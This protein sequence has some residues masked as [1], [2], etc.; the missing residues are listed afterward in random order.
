MSFF[1]RMFGG[2]SAEEE[3]READRLLAR[4]D[5]FEARQAYERALEKNKG[6]D[7]T[8]REHCEARLLECYD[9]MAE[10]RIADAERLR[11][12]GQLEIA[13]GELTTAIE[14]ARSASVRERARRAIE[15]LERRDAVEQATEQPE[16]SDDDRW[17]VIAGTWEQPQI[18]EY[19]E[20][21]DEFREAI[22]ALH[23]NRPK[24]ALPVIERLVEEH[25]EDATYL[26][27]E[28]GRARLVDGDEE[29]GADALR[30]FLDRMAESD[31]DDDDRSDAR[32]AAHLA[33]ASLADRKGDEE[34]AIDWLQKAMVAMP[35]DPRPY[36]QLGVYLREKGHADEAID[37]L[38]TAIELMDDDRPSWEAYQE[39]GL[40]KM[41]AGHDVEAIDL[42]EKVVRFFVSRSRLDFPRASALPLARLHEKQGQLERAADLYRNLAS[43]SDRANHLEYHREAAR[44]LTEL[45]LYS[46]ARRMLT[47][48]A[49]LAE[50][51]PAVLATVEADIVALD[52]RAD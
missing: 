9:A 25:G 44:V 38:E 10:E 20:Y 2:V 23:D 7:A 39:L 15:M 26:W 45:G 11:V 32:L 27:L 35:D 29:G 19:D 12:E 30:R 49:A 13:R 41:D 34:K 22:L 50:S 43:G 4:S 37:V 14:L 36:L 1:K 18:D 24:D 47:R 52:A 17:A 48:A 33:L 31:D 5:H 16:L 21:G 8:L 51:E 46:E 40:A 6:A 28:A 42:L 3:R